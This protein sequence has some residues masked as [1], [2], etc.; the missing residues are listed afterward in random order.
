M[1]YDAEIEIRGCHDEDFYTMEPLTW[2]AVKLIR[3]RS[4]L[5]AHEHYSKPPSGS[6]N[7]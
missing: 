5:N 7:A 2:R 3:A 4:C 1:G 6:Q